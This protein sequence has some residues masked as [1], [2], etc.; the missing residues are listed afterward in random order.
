M[1]DK[2]NFKDV[3]NFL[4]FKE[5][6]DI[7]INRYDNNAYL[8]VNFNNNKLIYPEDQGLAINERKLVTSLKM[9]ILWF[10]NV[11]IVY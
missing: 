2:N 10:L 11:C 6:G 3:L 7:F 9:R 5:S 1:I 4:G 8:K